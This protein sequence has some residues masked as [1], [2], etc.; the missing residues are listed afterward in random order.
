MK[1]LFWLCY[2]RDTRLVG[3]VIVEAGELYAAR[4]LAAISGLDKLADFSEGWELS[5]QHRAM[6]S[7]NLIGRMLSPDEAARLAAWIESEAIRKNSQ[8]A[9]LDRIL[10]TTDQR[11]YD[12]AARGRASVA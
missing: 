3:V 6:I 11:P 7:A 9:Q 8:T 2:R 10:L 1:P 12:G 4:M 5:A